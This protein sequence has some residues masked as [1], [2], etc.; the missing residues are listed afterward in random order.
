MIEQNCQ[1]L[2]ESAGASKGKKAT[3]SKRLEKS[4]ASVLLLPQN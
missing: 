3:P 2:N 4:S 1:K